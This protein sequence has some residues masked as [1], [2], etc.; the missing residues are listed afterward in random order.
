MIHPADLIN[1]GFELLG[2]AFTWR[3][4]L[5]L[6][7]DRQIK[8]VYWPTMAFFAV[9]GLWNLYYY[10]SLGQWA[11]F[12]AGV[13]LVAGNLAWVGLAVNLKLKGHRA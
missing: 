2:A 10:P 13:V 4:A 5:Q 12:A 1:A 7:R 9:L 3:N 8:G 6:Y 11:S